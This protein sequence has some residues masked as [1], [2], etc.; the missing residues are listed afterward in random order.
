MQQPP[1]PTDAFLY[2]YTTN[3]KPTAFTWKNRL[4]YRESIFPDMGVSAFFDFWGQDKFLGRVNTFGNPIFIN[5]SH[6]KQLRYASGVGGVLAINFVAD[7]WRDFAEK[8]Q[9]LIRE[10]VLYDSGPY[11]AMT[12]VKGWR[13]VGNAYHRHLVETI[14]PSFSRTYLGSLKRLSQSITGISSYLNAFTSFLETVTSEGGP[15]TFSGYIESMLTSPLNSGLVIE[16]SKDPHDNDF[17]KT[18]KY[19]YDANFSLVVDLATHYGFAIDKN[20]PWRFVA[21]VGSPAMQE[22]MK[23]V[24]IEVFPIDNRNE[25][26]KCD[27]V[28]PTDPNVSEPYGFSQIRGLE[29]VVRHAAGYSQYSDIDQLTSENLVYE[30]VY[31]E[32][33]LESW[34]LDMDYLVLYI[35]DFYNTYVS[36]Y[37]IVRLPPDPP[38]FN[39]PFKELVKNCEDYGNQRTIRRQQILP[40]IFNSQ[41]GT[42]RDKW[43]LKAYYSI[44]LL[45]RSLQ[46]PSRRILADIRDFINMYDYITGNTDYR[47]LQTL[48][49]IQDTLI[50]RVTAAALTKFS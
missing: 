24:P 21:D 33:F 14:Y 25:M 16:I 19:F 17:L 6:L 23:G 29:D 39:D 36:T 2:A 44:R 12:A 22:Y 31:A 43:N 32:A 20:A 45:E 37:P 13:S 40:S 8:I 1:K 30:V 47:Y 3:D 46:K 11:A 50:G 27:D 41:G 4:R 28:I 38:D 18:S 5:E 34:L 48:K 15:V 26:G 49:Y 10:G 42:F 35:T 7:A 9:E